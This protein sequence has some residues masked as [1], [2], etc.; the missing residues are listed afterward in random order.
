MAVG[1]P[2]HRRALIR[3]CNLKP[4]GQFSNRAPSSRSKSGARERRTRPSISS[5]VSCNCHFNGAAG[6]GCQCYDADQ[7]MMPL[8]HC[9]LA[10]RLDDAKHRRHGPGAIDQRLSV[11]VD[12]LSLRWTQPFELTQAGSPLS[13]TQQPAHWHRDRDW[14]AVSA[15]LANR[16]VTRTTATGSLRFKLQ[17]PNC[18]GPGFNLT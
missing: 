8:S 14:S 5:V 7:I 13:P 12:D 11:N 4:G 15:V 2:A 1:S 9:P 3:L 16:T 18:I 17:C 6:S 10:G